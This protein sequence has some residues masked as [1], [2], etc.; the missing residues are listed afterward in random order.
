MITTKHQTC[1]ALSWI[2]PATSKLPSR[3]ISN[4][5]ALN[6][7]PSNWNLFH[8]AQNANTCSDVCILHRE[9]LDIDQHSYALSFKSMK[10]MDSIICFFF[11]QKMNGQTRADDLQTWSGACLASTQSQ[12]SRM[13][14]F[15]WRFAHL[16]DLEDMTQT[17]SEQGRH[18]G[19]EPRKGIF[20]IDKRCGE[21]FFELNSRH[22]KQ[23]RNEAGNFDVK[24]S[25]CCV[26]SCIYVYK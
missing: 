14:D 19:Y 20:H 25:S 10:M 4:K 5:T 22:N 11:P 13:E 6:S 1:K 12:L 2:R 7:S 23:R 9:K 17:S 8:K 15:P 18:G 16:A 24:G 26:L 21:P 3:N